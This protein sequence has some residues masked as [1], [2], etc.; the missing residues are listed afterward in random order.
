MFPA[1]HVE[2][3]TGMGNYRPS[4]LVYNEQFLG[5]PASCGPIVGL[6]HNLGANFNFERQN[7]LPTVCTVLP[8]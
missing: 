5:H 7:L 2:F 6:Y 1:L 3:A 8:F 4:M